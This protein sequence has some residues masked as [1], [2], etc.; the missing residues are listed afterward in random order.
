MC[1]AAGAL[2]RRQCSGLTGEAGRRCYWAMM[3]RKLGL[4]AVDGG[5]ADRTLVDDLLQA[6]SHPDEAGGVCENVLGDVLYLRYHAQLSLLFTDREGSMTAAA[7]AHWW[8][9]CC[10]RVYTLPK[11][12]GA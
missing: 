2:L 6:R 8:Q 11:K 12:V 10:R 3:R 7:T 1:C 4:L 9:T 5:E